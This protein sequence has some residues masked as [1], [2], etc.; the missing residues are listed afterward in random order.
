MELD[1]LKTDLVASV[2]HE[3]RS[4]LT[5]IVSFT[6]LLRD[7]LGTDT[8]EDQLEFLEIIGRNSQRLLRLVDDLLVLDRLESTDLLLDVEQVAPDKLVSAAVSSIRPVAEEKGVHLSATVTQGPTVLGDK[9]R[10]GQLIDNLLSNAVKFTPSGGSVKATCE[11]I[12]GRWRI[13]V[14]DSGIGIPTDEIGAL[15]QRFY[16]ASN[17]HHESVSGSGLG[18]AIALR[19]AELH[20]GSITVR[21]EEGKGTTFAVELE[22]VRIPGT[23]GPSLA[24]SSS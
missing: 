3:L 10:L 24:R 8:L 2:S 13:E 21:S 22:G 16:R 7:G 20:R 17:A 18:L 23:T 6:H 15:F 19:I 11:P 14:A 12:G 4:P 5:S 1:A 9:D